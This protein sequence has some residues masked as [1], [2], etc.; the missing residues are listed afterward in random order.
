MAVFKGAFAGFLEVGW[1][2][3]WGIVECCSEGTEVEALREGGEREAIAEGK[4]GDGMRR[5]E[6]AEG[7][8]RG[9]VAGRHFVGRWSFG[10]GATFGRDVILAWLAIGPKL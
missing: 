9:E 4:N 8:R 5:D 2:G 7:G 3:W 10:D 6:T 1:W